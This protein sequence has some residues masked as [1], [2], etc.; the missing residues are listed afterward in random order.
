M[1]GTMPG[2]RW[3]GRPCTPWIDSINMWTGLPV[4]DSVRMTEDRDKRRKST[5]GVV[6]PWIE[7]AKEQNS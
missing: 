5:C 6:N 3:R 1:Q 4:E 7:R 2:A